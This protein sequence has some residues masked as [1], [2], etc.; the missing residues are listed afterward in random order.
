MKLIQQLKPSLVNLNISSLH[1]FLLKSSL[2]GSMDATV[3]TKLHWLNMSID[4][5]TKTG[6]SS[7]P[8]IL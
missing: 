4:I 2:N 6:L 1:L 7:S 5:I 8:E 3:P